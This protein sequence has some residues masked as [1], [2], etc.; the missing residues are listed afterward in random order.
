MPI[1]AIRK[2]DLFIAVHEVHGSFVVIVMMGVLGSVGRQH[3]IVCSQSVPLCI[4]VAECSALKHL[5]V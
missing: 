4:S 3:Q 5:V 2:T 1:L